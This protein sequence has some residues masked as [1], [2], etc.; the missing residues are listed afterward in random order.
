MG[1]GLDFGNAG[2]AVVHI[3]QGQETYAGKNYEDRLT[4]YLFGGAY[5]AV[6]ENG[7]TIIDKKTRK[8]VRLSAKELAT[9]LLTT[10]MQRLELH[11]PYDPDIILYYPSHT[12]RNGQNRRIYKDIDDHAI[13][14]DRVLTL[15]VVLPGDNEEDLFACG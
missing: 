15:R 3:L 7:E 5:D 11:Y 9:D 12:Y 10:K 1:W 6:N 14:A 8:P 4:G 13:D 2:S